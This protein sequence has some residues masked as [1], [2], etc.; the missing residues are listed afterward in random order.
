MSTGLL[1]YAQKFFSDPDAVKQEVTVPVLVW[2]KRPP[3]GEVLTTIP[4]LGPSAP[5]PG[6]PLVL[7]LKKGSSKANAFGLGITVGRTDNNDVVIGDT[8]ISRFHG[9]FLQDPKTKQWKLVD[10][11]SKN[12][13]WVGNTRLQANKPEPLGGSTR[14]R[15][16]QVDVMFFLP[17]QFF[18]HLQ[19]MQGS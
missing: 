3:S 12:G 7:L 13:T 18:A 4:G 10:A 2:E 9:Y 16:G 11:D 14:L 15:F 8:S 1:A 17:E 5:R 19:M 6:E